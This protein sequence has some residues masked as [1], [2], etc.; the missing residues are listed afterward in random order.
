MENSK[1]NNKLMQDREHII[2]LQ[3]NISS[4]Q[5]KRKELFDQLQNQSSDEEDAL[6]D[7]CWKLTQENTL[8]KNEM[9]A[10][11]MR[12]CKEIKDRKK[13]EENLAQSLKDRS[14]EC[15]RLTHENDMLKLELI[16]S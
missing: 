16:Q 12:M 14:D 7:Q 10:L 8:F 11:T 13:N 4:I 15:N 1:V 9:Q 3:G 5:A 6:K 2:S